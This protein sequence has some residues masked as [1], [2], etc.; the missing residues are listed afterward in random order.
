[1]GAVLDRFDL[2]D[3]IIGLPG[4]ADLTRRLVESQP[5]R[6]PEYLTMLDSVGQLLSE[7]KS[8]PVADTVV[9]P[10]RPVQGG[11]RL[12]VLVV[13][14]ETPSRYHGGGVY[15][16]RMLE[17]LAVHHDVTLIHTFGLDEVGHVDALRP[18]LKRIVSVPRNAQP[19]A[20][21][22][23]GMFPQRLYD[24]Y[25]PELRRIIE[26]EASTGAYDLVDY[27]YSALGPYVVSGFPSVL[28]IHE[29]G[30][31]ALLTSAFREASTA[32][33][34]FAGLDEFIRLLHYNVCELPRLTPNLITLTAEDA[35]ALKRFNA[36]ANLYTSP[37]GVD[38][39]YFAEVARLRDADESPSGPPTLVYV[40]NYQHPPNVHAVLF[41]AKEVM[42]TLRQRHPDLEF[43]VMGTRAPA[44]IKALDG[45]DGVRLLGFVED[46]RPA[47]ARALAYVAPLTTGT[48][49]RIKVAE[50]LAAGLPLVATRLATRGLALEDGVHFLEAEGAPSFVRAI[51]RVIERCAEATAIARRGQ[52]LVRRHHGWDAA[53]QR[54]NDIW[55]ALVRETAERPGARPRNEQAHP[56]A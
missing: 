18:Y 34:A 14:W 26:L 40:G 56:S 4:D 2:R 24:G 42:P 25:V 47:F 55:H 39:N 19:S 15:L 37:T 3:R 49:M 33:E 44:E 31:T 30:Y 32:D 7:S 36:S 10:A 51:N 53:V 17:G 12:R 35:N 48:G 13:S 29:M 8:S 43:H 11:R 41:F 16:T 1:V 28:T 9:E 45:V 52:D 50:A 21:R 27:E 38:I 5:D 46:L 22:G 54:R 20:Y 23:A 6:I